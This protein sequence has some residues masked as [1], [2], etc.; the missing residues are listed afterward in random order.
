MSA[1][2][3]APPRRLTG[4][5]GGLTS[6]DHKRMG[7]NLFIAAF[8]FFLGGGVMAL[9]MRS[10][11]A[12]ANSDFLSNSAYDDLFTMHGST[13][14]YLFVTPMALALGLYLVPLQIGAANLAAPRVALAGFWTWLCGGL[15]M[16]SGWFASGGPGSDGWFDFAP[17]N[18]AT[19]TPGTGQTM[20]NAGVILAAAG[21]TAIAWP[22]VLTVVRRRAPGMS[23]LR[24]S[25]FTWTELVTALMVIG[26]FPILILAMALVLVDR[27][28]GHVFSGYTGA[29][30]YQNLFW[31][32]GH[33]VVYVMFF[34]F[35][36]AA[37]EVIATNSRKRWFGYT[38]FILAIPSFAA[39]SMAVWAHHMF[40]TGGVTNEYFAFTSTMLIIPAGIEYFGAMGTM[41]GG[42]IVLRTS[43]LF[44]IFFFIEFFIGGASGIFVA[45]PPLD[46]HAED[47][48]MIVAHFH[49]TLFAGSV[50][51]FFAGVYHWFPKVTGALLR[52]GLGKVHC[53]LMVVGTNLAF[54]PM[55]FLGQYGMPRRIARYPQHPEWVTLNQLETIGSGIIALA[56]LV[57]LINV[58]VS[59]RRRVVAGP[60]PWGGQS[61]EWWTSSPPPEHNFTDPLPPI[62]SYSPLLDLRHEEEDRQRARGRKQGATP[63]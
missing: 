4:W 25:M 48:Y 28:G 32:F 9:L 26:S 22:L 30:N 62:R 40:T 14:I 3:L 20:W 11:L 49:Y 43:M 21:L 37:A 10:Q 24:C 59:L 31:F 33:P 46:Y 5:I 53:A 55:F 38:A 6:T 47:S 54:G 60:D 39:L 16:Q 29:I 41:L 34:P 7:S 1:T 35:L 42:S 57:F 50:F 56:V 2:T 19:F 45:S 36:G 52:E 17:L 15:V 13:M 8:V 27:S 44:A 18:N 51:G 58:W 63:A 23:M 12:Q 61:L